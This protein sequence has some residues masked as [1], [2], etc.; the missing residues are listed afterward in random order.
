MRC[1]WVCPNF[2]SFVNA[3][4]G[5]HDDAILLSFYEWAFAKRIK[6]HAFAFK[7]SIQI[8]VFGYMIMY[9]LTDH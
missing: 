3:S 8:Y 6:V 5:V 7:N 1:V 9:A 2:I 4:I